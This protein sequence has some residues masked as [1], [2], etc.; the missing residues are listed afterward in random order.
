MSVEPVMS[1]SMVDTLRVHLSDL[2]TNTKA[3]LSDMPLWERFVHL[4]WLAGPFILLSNGRLLIFGC[5]C[6]QLFSCS[7]SVFAISLVVA[8]ILGW[9]RF[10]F[11]GGMSCGG[12]IFH[13]ANLFCWR[14]GGLVSF[15]SF[16]MAVTFW[17][18]RDRRLVKAMLVD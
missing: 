17:L 15:S 1:K 8:D 4:F 3:A 11:L 10:S 13:H 6:W 14:S 18:G 16:A 12:C 9:G 5:R 2:F 7:F